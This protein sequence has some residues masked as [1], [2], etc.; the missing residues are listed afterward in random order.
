[1]NWL[2]WLKA[3]FAALSR[4]RKPTSAPSPLPS[5]SGSTS[6]TLPKSSPQPISASTPKPTSEAKA[7]AW[8]ADPRSERNIATLEPV[9]AK[10]A[11]EHLRRLAALGL[12]FKVTSARRTWQEQAALYAKGRTA[13]GPKV[14]N[15]RPGYS[16]HNFGTAYDLTLFSGKNPVW[17]SK[18]YD[19]AGKIGEDL[20]LE[21]GGRWTRLVDRPH[22]QRPLGLTLAQARAKHPG[23]V[24]V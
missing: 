15:A 10:L 13:P 23:G 7:S 11:R 12:N 19:T 24:I 16:W 17:E 5:S 20:G 18:H 4:G 9:T 14:T 3:S 2:Q 1:V 22:F 8:Q 21:W 6:P